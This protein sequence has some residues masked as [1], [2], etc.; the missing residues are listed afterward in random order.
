M[1]AES[2]N[3]PFFAITRHTFVTSDCSVFRAY[4]NTEL[5]HIKT[6]DL[7]QGLNLLCDAIEVIR[8]VS[9]L[10]PK[11]SKRPMDIIGL[12]MKLN[13]LGDLFR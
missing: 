11:I 9:G 2:E 6:A 12:R 1:L 4:S 3:R 5:Q 7:Q 10:M 8:E 13:F